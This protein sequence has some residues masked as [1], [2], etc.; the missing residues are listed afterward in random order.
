MREGRIEVKR[1][2]A[3]LFRRLDIA[4]FAIILL[5]AV[6]LF[7]FG[8]F[9][10]KGASLTVTVGDKSETYSLKNDRIFTLENNG[11]ALTVSIE[12]GEVSVKSSDCPDKIC[13]ASGKISKVGQTVVCAPAMISLRIVGGNGGELDAVTG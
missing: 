11:I 8:L 10:D 7:S 4:V 2:E 6:L 5:S 9:A 12:D 1:F 3:K 13:V